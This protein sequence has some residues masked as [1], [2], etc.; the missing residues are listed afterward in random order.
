M[1]PHRQSS[2]NKRV[3]FAHDK[4]EHT[5]KV[6]ENVDNNSVA[7]ENLEPENESECEKDTIEEKPQISK[8]ERLKLLAI[9]K[10]NREIKAVSQ[11]LFLFRNLQLFRFSNVLNSLKMWIFVLYLTQR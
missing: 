1:D 9:E 5:T 11:K 7:D 8:K 3:R 4:S 10:R 6:E 2:E